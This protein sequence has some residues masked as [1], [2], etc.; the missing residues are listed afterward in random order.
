M[1]LF[2]NSSLRVILGLNHNIMEYSD[3]KKFVPPRSNHC[4][5]F[6]FIHTIDL[7]KNN[8]F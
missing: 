4:I 1:Y 7:L 8:G 3:H 5:V 6:A 2:Y